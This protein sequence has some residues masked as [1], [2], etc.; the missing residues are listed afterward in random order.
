MPK[1]RIIATVMAASFAA[2]DDSAFLPPLNA[3]PNP[4]EHTLNPLLTDEKQ[5]QLN[6]DKNDLRIDNERYLR[7]HPEVRDIVTHFMQRVLSEYPEDLHQFANEH[8]ADPDLRDKVRQCKIDNAR[9]AKIFSEI[10]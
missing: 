5:K 10:P 3:V 9:Y 2:V 1:D 6:K 4:D 7:S 8:F